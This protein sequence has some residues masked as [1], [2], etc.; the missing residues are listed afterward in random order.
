LGIG[1]EMGELKIQGAQQEVNAWKREITFM[2]EGKD[3]EVNLFWDEQDGYELYWIKDGKTWTEENG[4]LVFVSAPEWAVAY[5]EIG[6][7]L[8]SDLDELSYEMAKTK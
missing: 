4:K 1:V 3:Y 5:N 8:E 6:N 2:Y 7:S